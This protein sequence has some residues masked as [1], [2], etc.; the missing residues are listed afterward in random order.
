MS[1]FISRSTHFI[2]A[3]ARRVPPNCNLSGFLCTHCTAA[4]GCSVCTQEMFNTSE[5]IRLTVHLRTDFTQCG[6]GVSDRSTSSCCWA[7]L[8]I[9]AL[10]CLPYMRQP[11][12]SKQSGKSCSLYWVRQKYFS[13][14]PQL[15][16][17]QPQFLSVPQACK[18]LWTQ[19]MATICRLRE[20]FPNSSNPG[21]DKPALQIKEVAV[22]HPELK[23]G[24]NILKN[25][26]WTCNS[27]R[28]HTHLLLV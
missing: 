14:L 21:A 24:L 15:C 27:D 3:I 10:N 26:L 18:Q 16:S 5:P 23:L 22:F 13:W 7:A 25:L 20:K 8:K 9:V 19:L 11:N 6:H 1:H 17:S 28:K 12:Q 4:E 2:L